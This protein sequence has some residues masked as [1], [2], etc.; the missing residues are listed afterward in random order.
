MR[1]YAKAYK[2]KDLR[3]F[4]GWIEQKQE[5]EEAATDESVVFIWDDFTITTEHFDGKQKGA[6]YNDVTPEWQEF[7]KNTLNFEIPEDVRRIMQ[8][9][10][11]EQKPL[12]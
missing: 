7:C 5:G 6:L 10:Q 3:Q 9:Q 2:L 12:A 4:N 8:E 1:I 11:S